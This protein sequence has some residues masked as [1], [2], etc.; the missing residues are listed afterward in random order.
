MHSSKFLRSSSPGEQVVRRPLEEGGF[1]RREEKEPGALC[2][3]AA[4]A[5]ARSAEPRA[6]L[7]L[8]EANWRRRS[9]SPSKVGGE[10][11][12]RKGGDKGVVRR[13][14]RGGRSQIRRRAHPL[15]NSS[16]QR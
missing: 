3:L 16:G 4:S 2:Q 8:T 1:S 11:P 12:G 15:Y 5:V 7:S 14:L 9:S 10:N 6:H 13:R